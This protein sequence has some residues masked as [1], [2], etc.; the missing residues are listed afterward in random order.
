MKCYAL[1]IVILGIVAAL[2]CAAP[3]AAQD[4]PAITI[5]VQ[6]G[7][8]GAYRIGDWFPVT[9][10][11]A[12]DGPDVSGVLEWSF[13]G[14]DETTFRRAIDLPRGS[15]KRMTLD[16]FAQNV[17]RNGHIRLLDGGRVLAEQD[18]PLEAVEEGRF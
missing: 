1:V 18:E 4:Q 15:R 7:Y 2:A 6:A 8:D 11:I 10:T 12:N 9:M 14:R 17:V 3:A 5:D 13:D 16:V